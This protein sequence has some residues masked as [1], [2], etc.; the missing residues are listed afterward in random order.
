MSYINF[1]VGEKFPL[2]IKEKGDGGIF[3]Y[4][5]NG[6]MFILKLS[7]VDIIAVEAFRTGKVELGLFFEKN[8]IFLLYKIDGV[9]NGWADSPYTIHFHTEDQLPK[10]EDVK[11]KTL[12]LYLVHSELDI[13]LSM[14][15]VTLPDDFFDRLIDSVKSQQKAPFSKD[16]YVADIQ[17]VWNKYSSE[18]MYEKAIAKHEIEFDIEA[19]KGNDEQ[20]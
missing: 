15:T 13:L 17:Q 10:L 8:I 2:I 16:G 7:K 5:V 9:I 3:Q 19:I 1:Q 20:N 11:E 12:S 6:A 18:E 4:D 14:R